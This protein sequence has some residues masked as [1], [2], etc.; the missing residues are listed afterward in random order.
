[1]KQTVWDLNYLL[2]LAQNVVAFQAASLYHMR[3][4][5]GGD[6]YTCRRDVRGTFVRMGCVLPRQSVCARVCARTCVC[7]HTCVHRGQG[8]LEGGPHDWGHLL[9]LKAVATEAKQL[10]LFSLAKRVFV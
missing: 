4:C 7:A 1:M 3:V 6:T 10:F 8:R 9:S 5:S 2:H